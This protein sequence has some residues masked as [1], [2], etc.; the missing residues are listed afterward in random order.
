MYDEEDVIAKHSGY[1]RLK[2]QEEVDISELPETGR[3][4]VH[5]ECHGQTDVVAYAGFL[6][7]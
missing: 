1:L 4:G 6:A 3:V 2:A 7:R 5:A